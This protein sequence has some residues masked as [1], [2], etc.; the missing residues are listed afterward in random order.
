VLGTAFLILSVRFL[1]ERSEP[2]ARALFL[3]S[4]VYLSLL[5][6]SLVSARLL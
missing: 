2:R 3:G 6:A 5:W 1:A 4:L